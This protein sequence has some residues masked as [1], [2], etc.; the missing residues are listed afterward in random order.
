MSDNMIL[1]SIVC[2]VSLVYSWFRID[3]WAVLKSK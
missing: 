3:S 2:A 1:E